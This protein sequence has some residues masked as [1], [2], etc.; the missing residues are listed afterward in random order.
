M[1][2]G[3]AMIAGGIEADRAFLERYSPERD[4]EEFERAWKEFEARRARAT[5][6]VRAA[7]RGLVQWSC[8]PPDG[9]CSIH[10]T[11]SFAAQAGHHLTPRL[12]SSGRN[13]FEELD[14]AGFTLLAFDARLP[15]V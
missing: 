12:L 14:S 3:E 2:T 1:E 10:G 11:Y 9:V 15:P 8:G 13:V 5:A 6:V 4:R 7:L